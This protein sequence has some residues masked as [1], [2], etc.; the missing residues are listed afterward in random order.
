MTDWLHSLDHGVLES[1]YAARTLAGT[2]FFI[3]ISEFGRPYTISALAAALAMVFYLRK[4]YWH[5]CALL[6]TMSGTGL[7]VL[8]LKQLLAIP[9]PA[10]PYPAYIEIGYAFP[11]AH[12]AGS[13]ALYGFCIYLALRFTRRSLARTAFITALCALVLLVAYS[14][15][16]LGVHYVSDIVGG[17]AVGAAFLALGILIVKRKRV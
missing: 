7:T 12:A 1:L 15:L 4:M 6:F 16:Y 2:D 11:S 13:I 3:V 5:I 10:H 14:R 9:R 8:L 17:F